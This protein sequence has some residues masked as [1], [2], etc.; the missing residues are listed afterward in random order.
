MSIYITY[1]LRFPMLDKILE[2]F[3]FIL[4]SVLLENYDL[5]NSS[6]KY[7]NEDYFI[8]YFTDIF[9][10]FV[11]YIWIFL[12]TVDL[13]FC[14]LLP[15]SGFYRLKSNLFFSLLL[16]VFYGLKLNLPYYLIQLLVYLQLFYADLLGFFII[17]WIFLRYSL[18]YSCYY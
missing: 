6:A 15:V 4:L 1:V 12:S 13:F 18:I 17:F 11:T 14:L 5:L 7:R 2:C 9:L 16:N 10:G 3:L 8:S